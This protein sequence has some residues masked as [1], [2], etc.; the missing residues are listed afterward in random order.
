MNYKYKISTFFIFLV[1]LFSACQDLDMEME[2]AVDDNLMWNNPSYID[3]YVVD[4]ISTMPNG[5]KPEE[6][7]NGIF[8]ANATDEAENSNAT[9]LVQNMNTGNWNSVTNTNQAWNKYYRGIYKVNLFLEKAKDINYETYTPSQ[10]DIFLQRLEYYKAEAR[11]LRAL[12][13]YELIKYYGGVV[14][15]GDESIQLME[16]LDKPAFDA[17]RSSFTDCAEY[18]LSECDYL[19]DNELL[20]LLDEGADQG[21]PNG[22]AV[23]AIACKTNLLLASTV[24]NMSITE[25]SAEQMAYWKEVL[26]LAQEIAFDK[27]FTF[28]PYDQFDGTSPEIILGYRQKEINYIEK[29]NFPVGCEGVNTVGSS[30]PTQN[31]VDAYRMANGMKI[32]EAGSGYDPNNPYAGRDERLLH[33]V[34]VNGSHWDERNT[35]SRTVEIFRGGRDGMDRDYGT[36]TGYYLRKYLDP[37]LDL[38]Q[39]QVS[40]REW[41]IFRFADIVLIWAEAANELYGPSTLGESYLT[42]I[43]LLNQTVVRH[44]GLPEIPLNSLSQS[45]FRERLREERFIEMAFEN[46]RAWDLRR[47]GIAPQVLSQPVYKMEVTKSVDGSYNYQKQ[48]LEDRYFETHMNLY[49]IPQREVNNGLVQNAGW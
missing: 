3:R 36:K 48:M 27:V 6:F 44:G 45:E 22:T 35:S 11:F 21:R 28:G 39:G 47:W 31:L 1:V 4:L 14:L 12:F 49:P 26:D 17:S 7:G 29:A 32:D 23:K 37:T 40:N 33:T 30:C 42:A 15:I 43:T 18:I 46:M 16:E 19:I 2:T 5:F 9:A 41:P 10:R 34:I 20:P 24:Y 13:Y 8:Y 25:G 38:R